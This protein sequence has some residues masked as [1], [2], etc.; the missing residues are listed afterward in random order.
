VRV[1]GEQQRFRASALMIGSCGAAYKYCN[2][3]GRA[4]SRVI[5]AARRI[6]TSSLPHY[7]DRDAPAVIVSAC[8]I[9]RKKRRIIYGLHLF[10]FHSANDGIR[11]KNKTFYSATF[12]WELS[13]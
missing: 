5:D 3:S 4:A 11:S 6:D 12:R 8:R 1:S 7:Y 2:R 13:L 10:V 9:W